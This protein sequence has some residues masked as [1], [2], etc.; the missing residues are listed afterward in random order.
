MKVEETHRNKTQRIFVEYQPKATKIRFDFYIQ[1]TYHS[2]HINE[3]NIN[4]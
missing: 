3:N 2:N 4:D 1:K